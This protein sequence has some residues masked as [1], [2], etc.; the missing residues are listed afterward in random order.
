M[1]G[2]NFGLLGAAAYVAPRHMRAIQETG[3][4]LIAALDPYDNVGI[5]DSFAPQCQ[6]FTEFERFDRP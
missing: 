5:L 6:F 3:N 2:L 4:N 1:S